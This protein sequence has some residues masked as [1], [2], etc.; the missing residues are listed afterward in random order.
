LVT[1]VLG[2]PSSG[3]LTSCTGL[4]LT[5]GVTGTLPV[6]NGG[7]GVTTS[8]G[9]GNNVLS[10]SPT[11]T[12]PVLGTPSSG[13]LT[14]CSGYTYANLAGTVPTWNQNTTG[15]AAN[16]TG[17]VAVANG[18]TGLATL[19]ANNVIL[20]NGTSAPSFVAPSTT[21]NVLT[22]NGTTWTSAENN[23][24]TSGTVQASTSGTSIDFTS[25]PSWVKRVTVIFNGV[26][27]SSSAHILIQIGSGSV[28][29]TG[30]NSNGLTFNPTSGASISS[31]AG[32]VIFSNNAAQIF[33]GS[34][35]INL[36]TGTTYVSN[37]TMGRAD[38]TSYC[39]IGAGVSPSLSGALDRVRITTSTG[40]PTFDA[41]SINIMYE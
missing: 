21:G 32:F 22:S 25:I 28:S 24:L 16:V 1:P 37:H 34:M 30:Y 33:N 8:T 13:T 12:T 3:T 27:I 36:L 41:G 39:N 19:T 4:P 5:T 14:N 6:A 29:T 18:G 40:V 11:L 2:T 35:T 9:T 31:T 17:T 15:T 10:T 23:K 26:S 7:T 20:G 38:D